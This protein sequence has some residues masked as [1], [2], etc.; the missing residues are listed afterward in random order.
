MENSLTL[1]LPSSFESIERIVDEVETFFGPYCSDDLLY[2]LQLLAS[3]AVTNGI[4]HGNNYDDGKNVTVV[5]MV[6]EERTVVSVEDQGMG[7]DRAR[8]SNPTEGDH[9]LDSGGRGLFLMERMADDV[10]YDLNGRRVTITLL[11]GSDA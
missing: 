6:S 7:F 4:E 9:L 11:R 1:I 3:E 5:F 8:V 10:S 2:K